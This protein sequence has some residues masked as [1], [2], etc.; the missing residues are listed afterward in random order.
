MF[1]FPSQSS[2]LPGYILPAFPAI[3]LLIGLESR[4]FC[5]N[6]ASTKARQV[7]ALKSFKPL[8]LIVE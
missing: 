8:G 6:D 5:W 4:S 1:V 3:A 7:Q 2:K